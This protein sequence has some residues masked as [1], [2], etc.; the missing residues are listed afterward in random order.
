MIQQHIGG[1]FKQNTL[2]VT[3]CKRD[4]VPC[5]TVNGY[6]FRIIYLCIDTR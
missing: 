1:L 3:Y 6:V 5:W 4:G 2:N